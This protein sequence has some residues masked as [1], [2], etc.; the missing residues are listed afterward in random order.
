M[1][2]RR[3]AGAISTFLGFGVSIEGKIEFKDTIRLD[4]RFKGRIRSNTGTVIIG[5][6]AVI[7]A[8]IIVDV[9]IIMGEVNG[10]ID[11]RDRIEVYPPARVLGDIQAPIISIEAG[12]I[13]NGKCAMTARTI[14]S[15]KTKKIFDEISVSKE[16]KGQQKKTLDIRYKL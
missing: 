15:K 2:N 6:K 13:F 1:K 9:A 16:L 11:A 4:G 12:V 7:N 8:E 10:V 14:S 3:K 5:E